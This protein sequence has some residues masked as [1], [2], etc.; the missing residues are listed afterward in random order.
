[1]ERIRVLIADDHDGFRQGLR[2]LLEGEDDLEI[3][4]EAGDGREVVARVAALHPDVVLMDLGMPKGG[5]VEATRRLTELSP[6]VRVLVLTMYD[7]D[8]SVH[9]ALEA[10]ARGYVLKGARKSE[11]TRAVRAV[12]SG[13]LIIGPAV[14]GRVL[15]RLGTARRSDDATAAFPMLTEREGAVLALLASHLTNPE[16]ATRLHL[17]DKTV[18]N[19]VSNIFAKLGV[20]TRAEAVML[21]RGAGIGE[22]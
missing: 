17:S 20:A 8:M 13:E 21:A 10:G 22:R 6:H 18:R 16:I 15:R 9:A 5:G 11:L 19:H 1:V 12:A 7:D 3:V 4:G 2:A 14:A